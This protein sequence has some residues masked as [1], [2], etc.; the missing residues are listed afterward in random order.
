MGLFYSNDA[1]HELVRCA[2][3]G[4]LSDPHKGWSQTGYLFTCGNIAISWRSTK[5]ILVATSSNLAKILAIYE[6]S[7]ECV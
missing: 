5:Q 1:N 7:R 4:F 6:A 3:A 2:D